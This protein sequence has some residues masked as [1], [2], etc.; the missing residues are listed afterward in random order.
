[1]WVL[2]NN[3]QS[4]GQTSM[5]VVFYPRWSA[6]WKLFSFLKVLTLEVPLPLLLEALRNNTI[7]LRVSFKTY[8]D[9]VL[10]QYCLPWTI[11]HRQLIQLWFHLWKKHYFHQ[12]NIFLERIPYI[13]LSSFHFSLGSILF[14]QHSI[15]KYCLHVFSFY[16]IEGS[17]IFIN[18]THTS[19]EFFAFIQLPFQR[20]SFCYFVCTFKSRLLLYGH[21]VRGELSGGFSPDTL[22]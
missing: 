3:K 7:Q 2:P 4:V 5:Y 6:A 16:F 18:S 14:Y 11:S 1:M 22:W 21:F 13:N 10:G 12:F 20:T 15:S 9:E 19:E 8:C 17:I